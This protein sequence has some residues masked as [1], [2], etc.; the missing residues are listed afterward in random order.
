[1]I[2]QEA[3]IETNPARGAIKIAR[4]DIFFSL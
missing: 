4:V 3:V 1:M 2:L